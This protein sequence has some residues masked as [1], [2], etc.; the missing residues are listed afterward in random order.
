MSVIHRFKPQGLIPKTLEQFLEGHK[1]WTVTIYKLKSYPYK[2]TLWEA[3]EPYVYDIQINYTLGLVNEFGSGVCGLETWDGFSIF[4]GH[5]LDKKL[6]YREEWAKKPILD[7]SDRI[8]IDI[9]D[10][11]LL[12]CE[13]KAGE[14]LSG[15]KLYRMI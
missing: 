7:H 2:T 4:D 1:G 10:M 9:S 14:I 13:F 8:V 3:A 15:K 6:I 5:F 12:D 11:T